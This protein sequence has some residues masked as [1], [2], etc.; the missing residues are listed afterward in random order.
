MIA[1]SVVVLTGYGSIATALE[2]VRLGA[3]HYLTKPAD[4]EN[5]VKQAHAAL[6]ADEAGRL[7][8]DVLGELAQQIALGDHPRRAP[9]IAH[10]Q[11][12][13]AFAGER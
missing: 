13:A 10:H 2:A 5:F 3:T 7:A 1:L 4:A 8:D 11:V 9:D 12:L 6:G